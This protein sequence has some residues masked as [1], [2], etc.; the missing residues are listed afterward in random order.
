MQLFSLSMERVHKGERCMRAHTHVHMRAHTHMLEWVQ[1][2][3]PHIGGVGMGRKQQLW[4]KGRVG[5][6]R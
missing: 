3:N 2:S 1:K 4:G 5:T 6:E